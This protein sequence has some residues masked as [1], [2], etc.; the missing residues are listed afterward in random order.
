MGKIAG[1]Q[2][3]LYSAAF[4]VSIALGLA[5]AFGSY[6]VIFALIALLLGAG[7]ISNIKWLAYT[8]L[9]ASLVICGSLEIFLGF[10]QANWA[11]SLLAAAL[12]I[13]MLFTRPHIC[14]ITSINS[15][16]RTLLY[17]SLYVYLMTL[18]F[19]ALVNFNSAGQL[20]VG[21][22][23]FL[24]FIAVFC[25]VALG[26][27][28]SSTVEQCFKAILW[29]GCVQWLFCVAEQL[30]VVPKRL[31]S[32]AFV[33]GEAEVIVGS[34]GG[35]PLGGGYTGEMACF[36]VMVLMMVY[37]LVEQRLLKKLWLWAALI[38]ALVA[39]GLAETKI[40]IV[41]LPLMLLVIVWK[42][43]GGISKSMLKMIGLIGIA[44][45]VICLVYSIRYWT[46]DGELLHA[47]TYSF[48]PNFKIDAEHRGRMGNIQYWGEQA[49]ATMPL[50]NS[51]I[52]FG[53]GAVTPSSFLAG[54]GPAV[55]K[56]GLG[57]DST[58]ICILLWN[59]GLIGTIAFIS[60]IIAA[61]IEAFR[62]SR[63]QTVSPWVRWLMV[64]MK[65]WLLVFLA[66]LP[67]Q[68]SVV[69]GVSMQYLFWFSIGLIAFY[70][71]NGQGENTKD[72]GIIK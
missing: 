72:V 43:P 47:F 62:L 65:S 51:F 33:G 60:M 39:I 12:F 69:A 52:G 36:T 2:L 5:A 68:P 6:L 67:Y 63:S 3:A 57:L 66:M 19:S 34:F 7:L 20:L 41:L 30:I 48:D 32:R 59:F 71:A 35:N 4:F 42:I 25:V 23:A 9:G 40:V 26:Y 58:A 37:L 56:Y 55:I 10:G 64:G 44:L 27:L 29:I 11:A 53:P 22:R 24:P 31:A 46:S 54:P 21:L 1:R 18:V 8:V 45:S 17:L 14:K 28:S 13:S 15:P 70:G 50:L 16:Y 61:F 49:F 38:S